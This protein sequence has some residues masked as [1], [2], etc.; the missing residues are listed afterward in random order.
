M[1]NIVQKF[2]KLGNNKLLICERGTNFGYDNLVVD[3]LGFRV[4]KNRVKHS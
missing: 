3:M 2:E 4:M 1:I